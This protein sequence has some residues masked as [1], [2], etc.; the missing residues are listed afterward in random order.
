MNPWSFEGRTIQPLPKEWAPEARDIRGRFSNVFTMAVQSAVWNVADC[1]R[2]YLACGAVSTLRNRVLDSIVVFY[3]AGRL[4][5]R[6]LDMEA[7]AHTEARWMS[8]WAQ[9]VIDSDP[10][11]GVT[12]A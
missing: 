7:I 6:T 8:A 12:L 4:D 9:L 11:G 10:K 2:T 3:A 5:W 1:T